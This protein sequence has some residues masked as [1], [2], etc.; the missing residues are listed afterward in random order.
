MGTSRAF[1]S[2]SFGVS[3]AHFECSFHLALTFSISLILYLTHFLHKLAQNC[4]YPHSKAKVKVESS[5]PTA[6]E[7]LIV[8]STNTV[9]DILSVGDTFLGPKCTL[10]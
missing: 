9:K 6:V 5:V 4:P 8:D 3:L 1:N 10:F 2:H 7:P